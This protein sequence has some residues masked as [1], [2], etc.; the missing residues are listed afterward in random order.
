MIC[1]INYHCKLEHK[2]IQIM[3]KFFGSSKHLQ[4]PKFETCDQ[5]HHHSFSN[6]RFHENPMAEK[7]KTF[8]AVCTA[9]LRGV[10][11]EFV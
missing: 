7:A 6:L 11:S 1:C 3:H 9:S 4:P 10:D 2:K 5:V 8:A